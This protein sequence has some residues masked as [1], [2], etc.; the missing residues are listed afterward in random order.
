M[1]RALVRH[2]RLHR[3]RVVSH[4]G[5]EYKAQWWTRNQEPGASNAWKK[6]G[7]CG[8]APDVEVADCAA[9]WSRET[10]YTG[11]QTVSRAGVNY[12]AQW[13]TKGE[14]PGSVT[15]GSWDPVGL[16]A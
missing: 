4:E 7:P 8:T 10:V 2:G 5:S 3:W 1:R 14:L 12:T 9:D 6:I 15:W 13:W 16:C 11:G